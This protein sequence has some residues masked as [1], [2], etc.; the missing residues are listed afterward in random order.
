MLRRS[1]SRAATN[2]RSS[3]SADPFDVLV[4]G[5]GVMGAWAAVRSAQAHGARVC[6]AD[7][8]TPAHDHGSSHGD[9]RIYRLAY[10]Q[11][12]YVDMMLH[13]LPLWRDLQSFAGE[14]LM[15]ETG[16]MNLGPIED[17][18]LDELGSLYKRR[19]IVHEWLS[20]GEA[21]ERFPQFGLAASQLALY[22]P[23]FGVLFASKAVRACWSYAASL[24]VEHQTPFRAARLRLDDDARRPD[25]VLVEGDDG[26]VISAKSV[27]LALGAWM[28]PL[29]HDLLGLR[30][31]TVVTAE[32]VS[33]YAPR[34]DAPPSV[35]HRYT[36]MPVFC[37]D[38]DNGL[39]PF[40]Y[41][42][43]ARMPSAS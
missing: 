35:D 2:L 1:L 40:G 29:A 16:G 43:R 18:R 14:P 38:D 9:G 7:Q 15:H 8:F 4:V 10:A 6:L 23:D 11:D 5:G 41:C 20:A 26:A 22:Q 42:A 17:N 19:G 24:G 12:L 31:P 3:A 25:V 39:G 33:Y 21:N 13:S 37:G 27:V 30:V 28:S 36:A 34:E 32:T